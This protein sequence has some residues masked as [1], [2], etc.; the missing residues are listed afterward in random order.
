MIP[1][2]VRSWVYDCVTE[3]THNST[4]KIRS[5]QNIKTIC[6]IHV[7]FFGADLGFGR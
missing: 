1:E 2:D 3:H 4:R 7:Y 6:D 5:L